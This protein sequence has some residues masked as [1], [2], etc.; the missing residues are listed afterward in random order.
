MAA[1]VT[2]ALRN[3]A[4][5]WVFVTTNDG[6]SGWTPVEGLVAFG[7]DELPILDVGT[8]AASAT[9]TLT[10]TAA[11]TTTEAAAADTAA[12]GAGDQPA[13]ET[14]AV[15]SASTSTTTGVPALVTITEQRLNIRSGPSA[16]YR[17]LGKA[18]P[19][20]ELT[21]TARTADSKWVRVAREDLR[22][23][24]GWVSTEF[25]EVKDIAGLPVDTSFDSEDSGADT[26]AATDAGAAGQGTETPASAALPTP[27]AVPDNSGASDQSGAAVDTQA[28]PPPRRRY[29][30]LPVPGR[31]QAR[32]QFRP[33]L[34]I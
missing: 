3:A 22:D 9:G 28:A 20:E 33:V 17:I 16:D 13:A 7:L 27:T 5:D 31:R 29:W 23:G 6:V 19:G 30:R 10:G 18:S 2:A 25:V 8:G 12:T 21:A 1:T 11:I 32:R 4:G 26:S 24:A 34:P 15:A 14:P